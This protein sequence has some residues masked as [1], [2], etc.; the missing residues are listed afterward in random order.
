MRVRAIILETEGILLIKRKKPN[1]E[2]YVFPGGGLEENE[3][4]V[5]CIV[6]ECEEELGLD[7]EAHNLLYTYHLKNGKTEL[8][9][10]VTKVGGSLGSGE[11]PEYTSEK[12]ASKGSYIPVI[13]SLK[14]LAK[15]NLFPSEIKEQYSKDILKFENPLLIEHR[16]IYEK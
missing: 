14:E 2:Y 5:E 10:N 16:L 4:P 13:V 9:Y 8:F 6:R 1:R 11:G 7:V 15:I 3:S 12:Y